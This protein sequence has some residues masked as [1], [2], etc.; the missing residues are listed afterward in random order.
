MFGFSTFPTGSPSALSLFAPAHSPRDTQTL[1][2]ELFASPCQRQTSR[3]AQVPDRAS[4]S[5]LLTKV[6]SA[7]GSS[8]TDV[9]FASSKMDIYVY[10]EVHQC[11]L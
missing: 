3:R 7:R 4:K 5:S 10:Q 6:A 8:R 9:S 11:T 2:S 1:Y